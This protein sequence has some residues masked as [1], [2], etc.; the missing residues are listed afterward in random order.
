MGRAAHPDI[1]LALPHALAVGLD[2]LVD[3]VADA[4]G[5]RFPLETGDAFMFGFGSG[6][7]EEGREGI[8]ISTDAV[9]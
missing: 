2:L 3:A 7:P 9:D 1:L 8:A 5:V 4:F 6:W